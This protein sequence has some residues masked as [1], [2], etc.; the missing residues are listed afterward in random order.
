MS[1][2]F[3]QQRASGFPSPAEDFVQPILDLN[4]HLV[5]HPAATFY[6]QVGS[7]RY[8]QLGINEQDILLVDRSLLPRAGKIIVAIV[9]GEMILM[10]LSAQ[11]NINLQ[12]DLWGVVTYIIR[13]T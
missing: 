10:Q 11:H 12:A 13:K 7:G 8:Q 4:Q 6:M 9:E 3:Q 2:K 1:I 5:K